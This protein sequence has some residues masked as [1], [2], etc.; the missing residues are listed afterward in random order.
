MAVAL[1]LVGL[2]AASNA[3]ISSK[4]KSVATSSTATSVASSVVSNLLGTSKLSE[5]NLVGTWNYTGPCVV[6]ESENV[7]SNIGGT[8]VTT[9]I[10]NE[11]K[12]LLEKFGFT[13]GKVVMELKSG[14]SGTMTVSGKSVSLTW[15]VSGTDLVLTVAKKSFNI[16]ASLSS[17]NLQLAMEA[18]KMLDLMSAVCSGA[19]NI[20][21]SASTLTTLLS[22]Y[23]GL[24]LGLKF[25]K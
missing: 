25:S 1:A 9:K 12:K 3:Q 19:S 2:P 21:S 5:K 11:E 17:G 23:E 6:L 14:G 4:L 20:S 10:E 16:N 7:L 8:V 13:A 22:K 24:Y 15:S 18:D